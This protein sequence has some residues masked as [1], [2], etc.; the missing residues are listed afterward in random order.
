MCVHAN[1]RQLLTASSQGAAGHQGVHFC[2]LSEMQMH[3]NVRHINIY[4]I[5][6]FRRTARIHI[7]SY[8]IYLLHRRSCTMHACMSRS[9]STLGF[10][11]AVFAAVRG[12][13]AAF[14][15]WRALL[16]TAA[17]GLGLAGRRAGLA[18]T[19]GVPGAFLFR[20]TMFSPSFAGGTVNC[21]YR[22]V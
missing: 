16:G 10:G 21:T 12:A 1:P 22:C 17:I 19:T 6:L 15:A 2:H 8:H 13:C 18:A 7:I 4:T 11:V 20:S 3:A 5:L 14:G 9:P